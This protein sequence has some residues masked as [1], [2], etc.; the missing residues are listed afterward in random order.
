MS[1]DHFHLCSDQGVAEAEDV[2]GVSRRLDREQAG[3]GLA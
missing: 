1:D 2:A 3:L